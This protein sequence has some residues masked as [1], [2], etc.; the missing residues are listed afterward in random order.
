MTRQR[1]KKTSWATHP[2]TGDMVQGLYIQMYK[3]GLYKGTVKAYYY[4]TPQGK[5]VT[6]GADFFIALQKYETYKREHNIV[7]CAPKIDSITITIP[8]DIDNPDAFACSIEQAIQAIS[9]KAV[10]ISDLD[11]TDDFWALAEKVVKSNL[12]YAAKRL[13]IPQLAY[14]ADIDPP[15]KSLTLQDLWDMYTLETKATSKRG[16]RNTELSW[17]KF[18][19]FIGKIDVRDITFE[20]IKKYKQEVY[21]E[22]NKNTISNKQS[23]TANAFKPVKAVVRLS[24]ESV[25][26]QHRKDILCLLGHLDQLKVAKAVNIKAEWAKTIG[27]KNILTPDQLKLLLDSCGK[28]MLAKCIILLGLNCAIR[29]SDLISMTKGMIDLDKGQYISMRHKNNIFQGCMLWGE[30]IQAIKDYMAKYPS[31]TDYIFTCN[32]RAYSSNGLEARFRKVRTKSGLTW[33]THN[34]LRKMTATKAS[35]CGYHN[36]TT[37]YKALMGRAI[38]GHD[39]S[40]IQQLPKDTAQLMPLLHESFFISENTPKPS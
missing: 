27:E 26:G 11:I 9:D 28:D 20:D 23:Y 19:K 31:T 7:I 40:Y 35:A 1:G 24:K 5:Q 3:T 39:S 32:G 10:T 15:M 14:I 29:W 18:C 2:V 8:E 38:G 36:M 12:S 4:K 17:K 37:A 34:M 6:C 22:A 30:T 33:L 21:K 16:L 13:N 25:T